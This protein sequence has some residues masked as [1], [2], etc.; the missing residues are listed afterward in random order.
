MIPDDLIRHD[1]RQRNFQHI[2]PPLSWKYIAVFI[3]ILGSG[4]M[5]W[6]MI[7]DE[8]WP[9][10]EKLFHYRELI[11]AAEKL[12]LQTDF[13]SAHR[14]YNES[15][16]FAQTPSD[17]LHIYV[18]LGA[19]YLA[20]H[21]YQKAIFVYQ[22]ALQK[23]EQQAQSMAS[24]I[25]LSEKAHP[26][27]GLGDTYMA[28]G[29]LDSAAVYYTQ[30]QH[31]YATLAQDYPQ[32]YLGECADVYQK[33]GNIY[34]EQETYIEAQQAYKLAFSYW[35][36]Q[37]EDQKNLEM[38]A[39]EASLLGSM[40]VVAGKQSNFDEAE[41]YLRRAYH[42]YRILAQKSPSRYQVSVAEILV[43]I[44]GLYQDNLMYEAAIASFE[45]AEAFY[46][47]AQSQ[48]PEVYTIALAKLLHQ[49]AYT[50]ISLYQPKTAAKYLEQAL[51]LYKMRSVDHLSL[52]AD[53]HIELIQLYSEQQRTQNHPIYQQKIYFHLTA[54]SDLLSSY[55]KAE[56]LSS[57]RFTLDSLTQVQLL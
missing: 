36:Q 11:T 6:K 57:Y 9:L 33:M 3:F 4:I 1:S 12:H 45:E 18:Q 51:E 28:M 52:I 8:Q 25:Y 38:K 5:L 40:G 56:E 29:L 22:R 7:S 32:S 37:S 10:D 49:L 15:L 35:Q 21:Q 46:R 17:S 39:Q 34:L 54:L 27:I 41:T 14:L 42:I 44:G 30:A 19:T 55:P 16:S 31:L 20:Q 24:R 53:T 48:Q 26:I 47:K 13:T 50:H 2:T 43:R 23:L